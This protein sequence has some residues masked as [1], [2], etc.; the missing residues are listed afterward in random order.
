V[1]KSTA[2]DY[3]YSFRLIDEKQLDATLKKYL[4]EAYQVGCQEK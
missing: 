4:R 2:R 3:I 1:E